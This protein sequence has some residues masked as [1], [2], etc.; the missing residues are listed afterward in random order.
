MVG[1]QLYWGLSWGNQ[2]ASTRLWGSSS[3]PHLLLSLSAYLVAGALA[4]LPLRCFKMSS[5]SLCC[6]LGH[7]YV[8]LIYLCA[9]DVRSSETAS[10]STQ[11]RAAS[12][13]TLY[14]ISAHLHCHTCYS[15]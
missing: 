14:F 4:W 15:I 7:V 6:P 12:L 2:D 3:W 10:L 11:A 1:E 8:C 9:S 5:Q 13:V